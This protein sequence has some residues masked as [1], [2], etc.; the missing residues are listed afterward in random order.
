MTRFSKE[1]TVMKRD[2]IQ[3]KYNPDIFQANEKQWEAQLLRGKNI[4]VSASAGSGKTSVLTTRIVNIL[5]EDNGATDIEDLLVL[6]FTNAAAGEMRERV[7][8]QL[9][10]NIKTPKRLAELFELSEQEVRTNL[11]RQ[12]MNLANANIMTIDSFCKQLVSEYYYLLGISSNYQILDNDELNMMIDKVYRRVFEICMT[13]F[14]DEFKQLLHHLKSQE[15]LLA[16]LNQA[17]NEMMIQETPQ[18]WLNQL[19]WAYEEEHH[20]QVINDYY[21][22]ICG[23]EWEETLYLIAEI[24]SED[25]MEKI[26]ERKQQDKT[27]EYM[28]SV[29]KLLSLFQS[30]TFTEDIVDA[31]AQTIDELKQCNMASANTK[32]VKNHSLKNQMLALRGRVKGLLKNPLLSFTYREHQAQLKQTK[33]IVKTAKK[34]IE[35][36]AEMLQQEKRRLNQFE[37]TDI[38]RMA[39][40]LLQTQE[41][42]AKHYQV[43]LNEILVDEYQ[44]N[45][46]LQDAILKSISNGHNLFMVGDVKQSIYGFRNA[47]PQLFMDRY[48]NYQNS[49]DDE[50]IILQ[51]NYRS[52]QTVLG[53][54]NF[55]FAQI[56]DPYFDR[57]DYDKQA[58]LKAGTEERL[59]KQ[60]PV[61][62]Y[63]YQK[64]NDVERALDEDINYEITLMAHKMQNLHQQ[65]VSYQDMAVLVRGHNYGTT[66]KQQLSDY[67]IPVILQKEANYY[68]TTEVQTIIALLEIIDNPMQDIPL[69]TVLHS[70]MYRLTEADL[71]AI[72]LQDISGNFYQKVEAYQNEQNE[73]AQTC[74]KFIEDLNEWR[75]LANKRSVTELL[76]SIYQKTYY[77]D[78]VAGLENGSQRQVNL[79]V[80]NNQAK[81]YE[82]KGGNTLFD[83]IQILKKH[84]EN[85]K[86]DEESPQAIMDDAVTIMTVHGSKGL[87]FEHVF[88]FNI[89]HEFN[90]KD[91]QKS[92]LFNGIPQLSPLTFGMQSLEY[93]ED[94]VI[95]EIQLRHIQTNIVYELM[96]DVLKRKTLAEEM[97]LL[98]VALT[99]AKSGLYFIGKT[100]SAIDLVKEKHSVLSCTLRESA[101]SYQHWLLASAGRHADI[102]ECYSELAGIEDV[103]C[104][105][106]ERFKQLEAMSHFAFHVYQTEEV[107]HM[108]S[109]MQE[110]SP[111]SLELVHMPQAKDVAKAQDRLNF[112]Y[113][114]AQQKATCTPSY[115]SISEIKQLTPDP[116][117][118]EMIENGML[119]ISAMNTSD[120]I[121]DE[122]DKI[123]APEF[124][125][126]NFEE[127]LVEAT[128]IG[129]ATHRLMQ[130]V[131]LT[132]VPTKES[133]QALAKTLYPDKLQL[134]KQLN[135]QAILDFFKSDVGQLL[136]SPKNHVY[137]EQPFSLL[138]PAS[139]IE[140]DVTDDEVLIH[141]IIDTYIELPNGHVILIDYKTNRRRY[142]ERQTTFEKRLKEQY[143]FQLSYY[144]EA[145]EKTGRVVDGVY[146]VSLDNGSVIPL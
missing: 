125:L 20:A 47:N 120:V 94:N 97:R 121:R 72:Q 90:Q 65:G 98:Y 11:K 46:S 28:T 25:P 100:T 143:T 39:Y 23:E 82:S 141:G 137:R 68:R 14:P 134:I 116:I 128:D 139:A 133:L 106:D 93:V 51:E 49:D 53:A 110:M 3:K 145:L 76:R 10:K 70:P 26:N 40:E 35:L 15:S 92:Y 54:T 8:K 50:L 85:D 13:Q 113:D 4:L 142:R 21:Q 126:P 96:K 130:M 32:Y 136:L 118:I 61:E 71:V 83:F 138:K 101:K 52:D 42:I 16:F 1:V 19:T 67:G 62:F 44:D 95:K 30:D 63:L 127:Q 87:E 146:I 64:E 91:T 108:D 17:V 58:E 144:K 38:E 24:L 122:E 31:I 66:I 34:V 84:S 86:P 109:A 41:S 6:T 60:K 79:M 119:N 75:Y 89:E 7:D 81:K 9:Q 103:P 115:R 80:L 129:L 45:N 88:L 56:Q 69:A 112:Q 29:Q 12:Q 131:D 114:H 105:A 2:I 77:D 5:A 104:V 102:K 55:I 78:Y 107:E 117:L 74:R 33:A 18:E 123:V 73:L 111:E 124:E 57:I 48:Q 135:I 37:F 99:R 132:T 36:Y 22:M 27:H 59:R 140:Q 43:R